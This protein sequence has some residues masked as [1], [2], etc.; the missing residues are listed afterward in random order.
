[1]K[2]LGPAVYPM[3]FTKELVL[4]KLK[5]YKLMLES[6]DLPLIDPII[7][8]PLVLINNQ[9]TLGGK[10]HVAPKTVNNDGKFNVTIFKHQNKKDLLKCSYELLMG[11]YPHY[12]ENL[13]SFETDQ[14]TINNLNDGPL[15]FFGDG[16]ILEKS[17]I[18]EIQACP[19]ALE[20]C[21]YDDNLIFPTSHDLDQISLL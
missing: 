14:L 19:E 9:P 8:A 5:N 20:V 6:P 16:E 13:I 3:I 11:N 18:L 7:E 17:N 21:A 12:D 4:G 2:N 1:M 15:T 10:F